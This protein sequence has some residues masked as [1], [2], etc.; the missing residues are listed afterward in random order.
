MSVGEFDVAFTVTEREDGTYG[1]RAA[2]GVHA[3]E[4]YVSTDDD[5]QILDQHESDMVADVKRQGWELL[6]GWTGQYGYN[7]PIMHASEY[8]G[9]SLR[10]H[11]LSVPGTYVLVV[12]ACEFDEDGDAGWAIARK[13]QEV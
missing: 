5:G 9:G 2:T 3:P 6:T 12:V 4:V 7:G 1:V 13:L 11:V 10:E 8:F